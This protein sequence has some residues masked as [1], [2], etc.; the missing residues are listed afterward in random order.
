MEEL[1]FIFRALQ[2]SRHEKELVGCDSLRYGYCLG[3]Q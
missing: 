1:V 3:E 2:Y